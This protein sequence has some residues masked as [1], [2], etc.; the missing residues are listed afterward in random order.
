VGLLVGFIVVLCGLFKKSRV[1]FL[2]WVQLHQVWF[3]LVC[4]FL[5]AFIT[6]ISSRVSFRQ[7][8]EK[9]WSSL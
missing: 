5:Y 3:E 9:S 7:R 6:V 4:C 8:N 1:G 2:G